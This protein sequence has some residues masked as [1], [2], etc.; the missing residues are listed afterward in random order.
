MFMNTQF[1]PH[2]LRRGVVLF[3][4]AV[5]L[6]SVGPAMGYSPEMRRA[7][8]KGPWEI[9]VQ[10]AGAEAVRFPVEVADVDKVA[11][12]D[13][14]LP[15]PG[16]AVRI[17]LIKYLPDLKSSESG[18]EDPAGGV[19]AL[20]NAMGPGVDQ[21]MWLDASDARRRGITSRAGAIKLLQLY[22]PKE[23]PLVVRQLA[24]GKSVGVLSVWRQGERRP[25]QFVVAVGQTLSVPASG[26]TLEVLDYMPHYSIDAK[27]RKV[28][29]A[30]KEPANPAIRIR[31]SRGGN[32]VEQW[33]WSRFPSSP[34]SRNRLPLRVEFADVDFGE[35][36][37]RYIL[38]GAG[39]SE[40][41][42]MFF[43]DGGIV[44]EKARTG[45][46]YPLADN[47][48]AVSI[49][50]YFGRGTIKRR[51][52]N[53]S[54]SLLHPAVIVSVGKGQDESQLVLEFNQ[55]KRYNID[56]GDVMVF[57]F[58]RKAAS[59]MKPKSKERVE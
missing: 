48:Y 23:L 20:V 53:A 51:W 58:A 54:E 15:I 24:E 35:K 13:R 45:K 29:N 3:A 9:T 33:L 2:R 55:P 22:D 56:G 27:T 25:L 52:E 7:M 59:G 49:K 34:H 12:L 47:R 43:K 42:I 14:L 40:P 5:M 10:R 16:S 36:A 37:G 19:I 44:A 39:D 11:D 50:K 38:A 30:S 8:V 1:R 57:V 6:L 4:V 17:R 41:W 31:C 32:S 26:Y 21:D 28:T 46:N 18:V